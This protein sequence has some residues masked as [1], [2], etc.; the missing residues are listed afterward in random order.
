MISINIKKVNVKVRM[1]NG[2]IN[3][4]RDIKT[5]T[6]GEK[7][8]E[9]EKAKNETENHIAIFHT[10]SFIYIYKTIYQFDTMNNQ[11]RSLEL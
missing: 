5:E 7:A 3:S 11:N 10:G 4:R 1:I 8:R 9:R 6:R 2:E